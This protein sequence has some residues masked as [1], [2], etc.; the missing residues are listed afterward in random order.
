MRV[1]KKYWKLLRYEL[2]T[3]YKDSTNLF[4]IV[5]P[6]MMLGILG[7]LV[8]KM[9]EKVPAETSRSVSLIALA[10]A[11][12]VGSYI[13]GVLLG[14]SLI[15]NKDENTILSLAVTPASLS[16]YTVFKIAYGFVISFLSNLIL[17]GGLKLFASGQYVIA[18]EGNTI[19]LLGNLGWSKVLVFSLVS[20]LFVPAVALV[21]GTY[22]KNKIEGFAF[23]KG[24]AIIII[25]PALTVLKTFQNE[26]QYVLGILPNF[27]TVKAMMNAAMGYRGPSDLPF[28]GYMS[29][30]ALYFLLVF[31]LAFRNFQRKIQN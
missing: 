11:F 19:G 22:A 26:L 16:G 31:Y 6:F 28:Y 5:Y 2:K 20:S 30:G 3:L 21:L 10:L 12:V 24:G 29:I 17:L 13:S 9:L 1:L 14:F 25:L 18:P 23:L 4:M 27:W 7:F 8:P 15:E